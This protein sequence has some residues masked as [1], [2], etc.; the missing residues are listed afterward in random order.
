LVEAEVQALQNQSEQQ[1]QQQE[2][3]AAP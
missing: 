2:P 3:V 1:Q